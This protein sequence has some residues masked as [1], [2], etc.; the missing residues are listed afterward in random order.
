MATIHRHP[1]PSDSYEPDRPLNDLGRDQF[2]LFKHV[3]ERLPAEFRATLPPVPSPED[4][5][6]ASRFIAAI[7]QYLLAQKKP[8][9][10]KQPTL[11]I[12][13]GQK[14]GRKTAAQ[15][16]AAQPSRQA[17][18]SGLSLAA[19]TGSKPPASPRGN[20]PASKSKRA[21]PGK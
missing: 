16:P 11:T 2:A 6:A 21:G 3:A 18:A 19:S 10:P 9:L 7:T 12:A 15:P 5:M 13:S 14:G 1:V 20:R 17:P 4:G 8:P